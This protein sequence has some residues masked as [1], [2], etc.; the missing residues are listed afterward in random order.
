MLAIAVMTLIAALALTSCGQWKNPYDTLDKEGST[1]SVEF[2]AGEGGMFAGTNGVTVV[3][4]FN[5]SN[6]KAGSDG[7]VRIPLIEPNDQ[8]RGNNAFEISKT[9]CLLAGWF[10]A[11][12]VLDKDGNTVDYTLGK[13][14]DF[15]NDTLALDKEGSYSGNTPSLTLMAVW[16]EYVEFE[17][18]DGDKL[19]GTYKGTSLDLPE[20]NLDTGKLNYKNF[21]TVPGKTLEAAYLDS[22]LTEPMT[23]KVEG[24]YDYSTGEL[25]TPTIKIYTTWREGEWFKISNVSQFTKNASVRGCYELLSDLDFSDAAW[26]QSFSGGEFQGQIIGNGHTISGIK[27]SAYVTKGGSVAHGG[28]F[29]TLSDRAVIDNVTFKNITYTV[30]SAAKATDALFGLFA[31]LDKGAA[32]S[33]VTVEDSK[34]VITKDFAED[35]GTKLTDESFKVALIIAEG[36]AQLTRS[37]VTFELEEGT[38]ATVTEGEGGFLFFSYGNS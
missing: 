35:F 11:E 24:E 7:K 26:P 37:N 2:L 16:M 27:T 9:G 38:S 5:L 36:D 31:G 15:D 20:W 22:D 10:V 4:V 18:Y 32:I 1:V 8:R 14:W 30:K 3:D 28:V 33:G 29:G 17:F 6:Y 25:L 23:G 19:I 13:K 34:I 12:P 21:L